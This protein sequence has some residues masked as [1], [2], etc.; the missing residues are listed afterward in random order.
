MVSD[1]FGMGLS[2]RKSLT[3]ITC[4]PPKEILTILALDMLCSSHK[5]VSKVS[6]DC[7]TFWTALV[8]T[9]FKSAVCRA[10][11]E[12]AV[13]ARTLSYTVHEVPEEDT[14][15]MFPTFSWQ[16]LDNTFHEKGLFPVSPCSIRELTNRRLLWRR[17]HLRTRWTGSTS[18]STSR[19][20]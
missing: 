1:R 12:W 5:M 10:Y 8:T 7:L 6:R 2:W 14:T 19:Q 4:F 11:C 9:N 18:T 13:L 15:A 16:N 3:I 17:R 20:I